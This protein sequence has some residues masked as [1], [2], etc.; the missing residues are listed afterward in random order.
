M[1][2]STHIDTNRMRKIGT[3]PTTRRG[4]SFRT[5]GP[6]L[7]LTFGLTW[8][9]AALMLLFM[10]QITA[11]FGE[12]SSKNPLFILAVYSPALSAV[13]LVWRHYGLRGLGSYFRRLTVRQMPL[14]WWVFL[15]L[16]IPALFY[17]AAAI[18]GPIQP[19]TYSPWY[20]VLPA[21]IFMLLLGPIEEFGWRGLALPLLQRRWTPLG[22]GLVLGV[23]WGVWHLPAFFIGGTPQ[24]EWGFAAFFIGAIAISVIMTAMFNSARGSLLTAGLFHF[25]IN[26]PIWPDAQPWDMVVFG[27]AA[28]VIVFLYRKKMLNREGAVTEVLMP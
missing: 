6:F 10:D 13:L 27:A 14:A 19:F 24:S 25:Q 11:I 17:L 9:L 7:A 28:V 5:L 26:N 20:T 21:L 18:L 15:V 2:D 8:G 4:M 12:M 22:A 16:G 1:T 23:I 3:V